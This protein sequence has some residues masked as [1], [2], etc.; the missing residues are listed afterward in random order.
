MVEKMKT[1]VDGI[2]LVSKMKKSSISQNIFEIFFL[3][4]NF[5]FSTIS[6][7]LK[8]KFYVPWT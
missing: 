7:I 2:H 6:Q 1:D 3:H 4:Q 8:T 5:N